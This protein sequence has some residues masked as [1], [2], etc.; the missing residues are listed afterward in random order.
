M[1]FVF[2]DLLLD[3]AQ[4]FKYRCIIK[5]SLACS[6][7]TSDLINFMQFRVA[8]VSAKKLMLSL[9]KVLGMDETK[10]DGT[11]GSLS[12]LNTHNTQFH[13]THDIYKQH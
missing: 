3:L 12:A 10:H 8:T 5:F 11:N 9:H 1:L 2:V 4:P 13:S 7:S 6:L